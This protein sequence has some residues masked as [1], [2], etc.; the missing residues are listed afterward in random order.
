MTAARRIQ[1]PKEH[2][3][4][5]A[6]REFI[7]QHKSGIGKLIH[8]TFEI[9]TL[10]EAEKLSTMLANNYP[11]PERVSTGIW[12]LISN[13]IEHGNLE[14]DYA[15]KAQL[16]ESG[17]FAGEIARRLSVSPYAR[18]VATVEFKRTRTTIR[19]RVRDQGKGFDFAKYLNAT[20]LSDGP[21]GR[22][23]RIASKFSF[24]RVVYRGRGNVVDAI[25]ELED[26]AD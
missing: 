1:R 13:A 3:P 24:D 2:E 9:R 23:I 16:L 26:P 25:V 8:G 6:I 14:I 20:T 18:R 11:A 15:E 4:D 17:L 5:E 10:D 7:A 21:N 19:I 12:E 22:G